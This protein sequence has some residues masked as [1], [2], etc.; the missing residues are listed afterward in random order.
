MRALSI[1]SFTLILII[2]GISCKNSKPNVNQLQQSEGNVLTGIGIVGTYEGRLPCADC[3]NISTVLNL[4]NNKQYYLRYTY[5]GKSDEV[6]EHRG[7]WKINDDILSLENIDYDYKI[8][9]KQL[10]QLDLSGKEIKG[11]LADQYVLVKI[12]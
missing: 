9:D 7:R 6:F 10:N 8:S 12:D 4:S 11:D 5:V 2:I 3:T 1:I